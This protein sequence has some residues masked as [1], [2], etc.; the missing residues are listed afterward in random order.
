MDTAVSNWLQGVELVEMDVYRNMAVVALEN[1]EK[2]R[3]D[4]ITLGEGLALGTLSVRE[5]SNSGS[6]RELKVLNSGTDCVL[7]LDG[8]ELIGAKSQVQNLV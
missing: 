6:V 8:E 3:P 1:K 2:E 7:L 5:V 4:Y